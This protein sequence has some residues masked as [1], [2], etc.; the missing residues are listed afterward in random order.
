MTLR[1]RTEGRTGL[2]EGGSCKHRFQA[3]G[4][5]VSRR[6]LQGARGLILRAFAGSF[7]ISSSLAMKIAAD[8]RGRSQLT[9]AFPADR[10]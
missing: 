7:P 2:T 9:V 1:L 6:S 3:S 10:G 4:W 8:S 5:H